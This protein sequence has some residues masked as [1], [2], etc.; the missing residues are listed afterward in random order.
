MKDRGTGLFI[1][2]AACVLLGLCL[3]FLFVGYRFSALCLWALAAVLV[4]FGLMRRWNTKAA[5]VMSVLAGACLAAGFVLFLVAEIP[6]WRDSRSSE[7]TDAPYIIVFGAAVHGQTPSLSLTER[8][9]AALGWLEEHPDGVAVLSGGQGA[10]EEMSE[11]RAMYDWLTARGIAPER[12]LMETLSTSSYENLLFSLRV[13]EDHGGDP[14]GT[15]AL[16]SSEYHLC[17][18]R[19]I[20]EA[21]DCQPVMVA[22]HTGHVT[23]RLNYA[24][25]EAFGLWRIWVLGPG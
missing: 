17:R 13:I 4:F 25:R 24:V 14:N 5:R 8:M 23:L 1:A 7:D 15:V 21:L 12:L 19:I 2:A 22:A 3:R 9:T 20:A 6:V 10:G 16:C 18:L 11:A